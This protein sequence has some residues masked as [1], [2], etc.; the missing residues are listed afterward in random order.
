MHAGGFMAKQSSF[1]TDWGCFLKATGFLVRSF[2]DTRF[3]SPD[4][5]NE[6]MPG[7][8]GDGIELPTSLP[9]SEAEKIKK[10]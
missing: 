10:A 4:E 6:G 3:E 8:Q 9:A 7:C 5:G 2:R 1:F